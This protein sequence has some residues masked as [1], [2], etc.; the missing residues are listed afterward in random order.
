MTRAARW[1]S[2]VLV[3]ILAPPGC[4]KISSSGDEPPRPAPPGTD[5]PAAAVTPP[6][7]PEPVRFRA[8]V[9]EAERAAASGDLPSATALLDEALADGEA[10]EDDRAN[11]LLRLALWHADPRSPV[12]DPERALEM[13]ERLQA[14]HGGT[15]AADQARAVRNL[16][17]I[18]AELRGKVDDLTG[19]L[20]RA[21]TKLQRR[22]EEMRRIKEILLEEKEPG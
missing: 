18:A 4:R 3:L 8:L 13:L 22:E 9:A 21:Q 19:Q 16:L 10:P 15:W 7:A 5:Q 11:V 20:Q 12:Q 17:E 1:T 14:D 2:L 6:A